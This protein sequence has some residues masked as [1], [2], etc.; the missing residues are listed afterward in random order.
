MK[1]TDNSSLGEGFYLLPPLRAKSRPIPKSKH[2]P[3]LLATFI[4][5]WGEALD[6]SFLYISDVI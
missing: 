5:A 1:A 3:S 4:E 6:V 2:V